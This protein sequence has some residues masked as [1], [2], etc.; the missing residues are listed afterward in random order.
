M[1]RKH[2]PVMLLRQA[3]HAVPRG[4]RVGTVCLPKRPYAPARLLGRP[5]QHAVFASERI[6]LELSP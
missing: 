3:G 6:H 1:E 2:R 5:D 4:D